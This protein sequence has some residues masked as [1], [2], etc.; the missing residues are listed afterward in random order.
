M[1]LRKLPFS[2]ALAVALLPS[3]AAAEGLAVGGHGKANLSGASYP[4]SSILRD[5]LGSASLDAAAEL[6]VNIEWRQ[7]GWS[8]D[9]SYQLTTLFSERL[10]T[11]MGPLS[12]FSLF[13]T[14]LPGDERRLMDLTSTIDDSGDYASVQRL[15]RLWVGYT[16]EKTVLRFGRQ[17]LSWGNGLFYAPMDLVN[18]FDPA[19]IDTEY[20]AGDDM[21]YFQYLRDNGADIQSAI[22]IRRDPQNGDVDTNERTAALKYHGFAE[23]F[24]FDLLLAES[25]GD[26]VAGL[27]INRSVGGAVVGADLVL[28][29]TGDDTY[30]EAVANLSYSWMMRGKNVTGTLEYY[31]NGFGQFGDYST[32]DL[33]GDPELAGRL[34]RRQQFT[35]GRQYLA[36]SVSIEMTPLWT[37]SPAILANLAD[38]SALIQLT[39]SYSLSDN[40]TLLGNL[41]LPIGSDGSEFGGISVTGTGRYLSSGPGMFVQVAWY[42]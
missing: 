18:P 29:D 21:L 33:A 3:L 26:V 1:I 41:N 23:S 39:S 9:A 25:Y 4:G 17:A 5:S 24:E 7:G 27:G 36:G 2:I 20:K 19:A 30:V 13:G 40:M 16:N 6:R 12:A 10:D 38:P 32:V 28:T 42:F 11:A 22:V 31:F 8:A 34:A 37:L 14:E 35:L 15:D